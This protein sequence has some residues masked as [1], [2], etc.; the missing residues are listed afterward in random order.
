MTSVPKNVYTD[1]LNNIV[2]KYKNTCCNTDKMNSIDLKSITYIDFGIENNDK[3]PKFR[4]ADL[5]RLLKYKNIFAKG[6]VPN[7][8]ERVFVIKKVKNTVAWTYVICDLMVKKMLE[9]FMKKLQQMNQK[10]F[11]F[12]TVIKRKDDKLYVQ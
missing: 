6:Y 8:S 10:E 3:N 1:I 7:W 5:V 11:R 9:R 2:N 12:E 4:V